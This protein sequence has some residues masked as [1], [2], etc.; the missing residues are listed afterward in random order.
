MKPEEVENEN[1]INGG[2]L[3]FTESVL[4]KFKKNSNLLSIGEI[5]QNVYLIVSGIVEVGLFVDNEDKIIEFVLPNEFTSSLSSILTQQPSDVYLKCLTDCE[6]RVISFAKL[7]ET[8]K[9]SLEASQAYVGAIEK[10]Y[11]QRVKREKDFLTLTA[12]E[13]Y[14]KLMETRPEIIKLIPIFRIAK[15]I[16]IHPDSLSRIR[17]TK[18][19]NG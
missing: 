14:I 4:K 7:R 5:E 17:K 3:P 18:F 12:E 6:I 13:R 19:M 2:I 11:V 8:A 1:K 15:Y 9:T 16:G 10:A